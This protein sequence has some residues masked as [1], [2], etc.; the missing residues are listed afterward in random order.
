MASSLSSTHSS[1]FISR[2]VLST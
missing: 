2:E 1:S